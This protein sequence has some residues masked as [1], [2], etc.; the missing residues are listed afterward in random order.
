MYKQFLEA[1]LPSQG[2]YC[3]FTLTDG[4]PKTRFAE[5]G[6]IEDASKFIEA[7]KQ[8]PPNQHLLSLFRRLTGSAAKLTIA[9]TLSHSF[10][11]LM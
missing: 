11:T 2:N 8:Q 5:N 7:F 6:S 3:I 1:V 10:L 9:S 4:K